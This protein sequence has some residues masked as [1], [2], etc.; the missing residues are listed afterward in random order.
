[1]SGHKAS[2]QALPPGYRLVPAKRHMMVR[3]ADGEL[4]RHPDGRPLLVSKGGK[5]RRGTE[6]DSLKTIRRLT[7]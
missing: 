7:G 6:R 4:V 5:P 1:M 2:R 3:D